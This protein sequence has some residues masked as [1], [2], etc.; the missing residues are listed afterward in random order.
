MMKGIKYV[1]GFMPVLLGAAS[2]FAQDAR[3]QSDPALVRQSRYYSE[4]QKIDQDKLVHAK[5]APDLVGIFLMAGG[6]EFLV[7]EPNTDEFLQVRES[8]Y[9]SDR[10]TSWTVQWAG[11]RIRIF[12]SNYGIA[13]GYE[14][15]PSRSIRG[16]WDLARLRPARI[17]KEYQPL[18]EPHPSFLHRVNDERIAVYFRSLLDSR[19]TGRKE[20]DRRRLLEVASALVADYPDDL[21]VRTL[22]L[23]AL[24][25]S[26]K[27]E[28][29]DAKLKAW[30]SAY[31]H[32]A[33][34]YFE[35]IYERAQWALAAHRLS[36][37][38][39]NAFDLLQELSSR[40]AGLQTRLRMLPKALDYEQFIQPVHVIAPR[41]ANYLE[42]QTTAKVFHTEATF[43]MI[44]GD[45]NRAVNILLPSYHLGRLIQQGPQLIARLI[46]V[47]VCGIVQ[48]GLD[49][50]AL[51][52][53]R[54]PADVERLWRDL[55]SLPADQ[56]D[57][58]VED[59]LA[60][61]GRSRGELWIPN[62]DEP[63]TRIRIIKARFQVFRLAMAARHRLLSE[64]R[65]PDGPDQLAPLLPEGPPE[66]PFTLK[67]VRFYSRPGAF[68]CY[69]LGP[70]AMDDR[71]LVEYDPTNG[72][73]SRGDVILRVPARPEY[74]FPQGGV[75]A[76][77]A[78]EVRRLFPN[79]LPRDRFGQYRP[80]VEALQVSRSTPV[81]VYSAG[82]DMG[83]DGERAAWCF[84]NDLR[85]DPTNG[86]VSEGDLFTRIRRRSS[87]KNSR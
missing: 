70:D 6:G 15:V 87:A 30:E 40:E 25:R 7:I 83:Y 53:C 85:Y 12:N 1:I 55:E 14:I 63:L 58:S 66:D 8:V 59:L 22:Y 45:N 21:H 48:N 60:L 49:L 57:P 77:T 41:I 68:F 74:P 73:L 44:Q 46:G 34:G 62:T 38:G 79:G 35:R 81:Y 10:D 16:D 47:A 29:M 67:P 13:H 27:F 84:S 28:E 19:G 78:D 24:S 43:A 72:T 61:E 36:A 51:N 2:V 31:Q 4:E 3:E 5:D 18:P 86:T 71:A 64:G 11:K 50:Y 65:F 20:L 37:S 17:Q 33:D 54:T 80:R 56:P 52:A 42:A 39:R 82:P 75:R 69:S 23:D 26:G 32:C 9:G 76:D